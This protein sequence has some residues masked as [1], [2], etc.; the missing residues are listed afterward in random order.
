MIDGAGRVG[1]GAVY[2]S[3]QQFWEIRHLEI[4]NDAREGGDRRGVFLS[5]SNVPG[6]VARHLYVRDC[7]IHNIKGIISHG[8][9][10]N[11][12]KRT[13]GVIVEADDDKQNL[14]RFDDILIENCIIS[15]V[16]NEGIA[17]SA[18]AAGAYYPGSPGWEARKFTHV[19]IRGN[20]IN[21]VAKN[22]MII[23][24]TDETG[25]IEHNVC[26]DT[27]YRAKTGNTIFSRS[28]RGTVFQFNEGYLNRATGFDGSL[29]DADLDSPHCVFQ[30]SYS[31]DNNQGLFWQCT[32][33]ND[34]QV[35]LRY[36]ISQNDKGAIFCMNYANTST[37]VY[38]NTV[39]VPAH[40]SP[41]I[42]DERKKAHKTYYFYNNIIYN[43]SR[44]ATYRW[45]DGHRSFDGNVFYG[46]HP[47][48]EPD[49]PHKLTSDPLLVKPGAGDKG[50]N[51]L[52][53]Y[54]L[55]PGSPCIDSARIIPD[56]GG[57]D[58]WSNVVPAGRG[59]DRGA[60]EWQAH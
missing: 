11:D 9:K 15:T 54:K 37:Y 24:M 33:R 5:I 3:N 13:G 12:A 40:L 29:Y 23:R 20:R 31:H 26:Y 46:I 16:D 42:I 39:Y 18:E 21:D 52:D 27:A 43:L 60:N 25:L 56:N 10:E 8:D 51:T 45:H 55:R 7:Y 57:L 53:G 32:A 49:D 2:L 6:N 35:I 44:T 4:V 48:G 19:V 17:L 14:T 30:Y 36:N 34:D 41:A 47:S 59:P 22:A 28:C 1:N 50:L 38:N 58:F